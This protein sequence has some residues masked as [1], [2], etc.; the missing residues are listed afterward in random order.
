MAAN[1]PFKLHIV[2]AGRGDAMLIE[3]PDNNGR[4]CLM[5]LD[6]GPASYAPAQGSSTSTPYWKY[7]LSAARRI[8]AGLP[9]RA[10]TT[11]EPSHIVATHAHED[12]VG[13][14]LQLLQAWR[15]DVDN[16]NPLRLDFRGNVYMPA[17]KTHEDHH[18][19]KFWE[20]LISV[21]Y[22]AFHPASSS[23]DTK[24]NI[25]FPPPG[26]LVMFTP[27]QNAGPNDQRIQNIDGLTS[28]DEQTDGSLNLSSILLTTNFTNNLLNPP[29][30]EAL[31]TA[32]SSGWIIHDHVPGHEGHTDEEN[33]RRLGQGHPPLPVV[34][35]HHSV[36][37][38][39]HHGSGI[40][41]C[42]EED[43]P[44]P[45][46][47]IVKEVTLLSI[48]E[49]GN[50]NGLTT[51][52]RRGFFNHRDANQ[53]AD[54]QGLQWL[55]AQLVDI[56]NDTELM[57]GKS[58]QR[59]GNPLHG[60]TLP[61]LLDIF[62][63]RHRNQLATLLGAPA[64]PLSVDAESISYNWVSAQWGKLWDWV[65]GMSAGRKSIG[66]TF[67]W[68]HRLVL[69]YDLS[70]INGD[71]PFQDWFV[72][73][74]SD[75]RNN[76]TN[77]MWWKYWK[78]FINAQS[79][80]NFFM[81]FTAD[82]YV[83]SANYKSHGHPTPNTIVG[84]AWAL[85][86]MKVQ[87]ELFLTSAFSLYIEEI[88]TLT[89]AISGVYQ[90]E[91]VEQTQRALFWHSGRP[92]VPP[93]PLNN[94]PGTVAVPESGA[95]KISHMHNRTYMTVDLEPGIVANRGIEPGYATLN[96]ENVNLA[97]AVD[98][99]NRLESHPGW[100]D[101]NKTTE[102]IWQHFETTI[103]GVDFVMGLGVLQ[104]V[105]M[106]VPN[107]KAKHLVNDYA[108]APLLT[109]QGWDVAGE[110]IDTTVLIDVNN[111]RSVV[112]LIHIP[113]T[114]AWR[115]WVYVQGA[116]EG[117]HFVFN[118]HANDVVWVSDSNLRDLVDPP[119]VPFRVTKTD[120]PPPP[121]APN[122]NLN[123]FM[124]ANTHFMA[125]SRPMMPNA[126]RW[127]NK[128]KRFS[129]NTSNSTALVKRSVIIDETKQP[130]PI[131]DTVQFAEQAKPLDKY[132]EESAS[133]LSGKGKV[134]K[135]RDAL[136]A[137]IQKRNFEKLGFRL[138]YQQAVLEYPVDLEQS[139]AAYTDSPVGTQVSGAQLVLTPPK[140][141]KI[142]IDTEEFEVT[143]AEIWLSWAVDEKL[144]SALFVRTADGQLLRAP[145]T[146]YA[147]KGEPPSLAKVLIG[148]GY[149]DH[150]EEMTLPTL[151]A[152]IFKSPQKAAHLLADRVPAI[153][154]KAG[155]HNLVPDLYA[156]TA[157]ARIGVTKDIGLSRVE[158]LCKSAAASGT[159]K[160]WEP[161][162]KFDDGLEAGMQDVRIIITNANTTA[163]TVTILA[164]AELKMGDFNATASVEAKI[165]TAGA[166]K[167]EKD[168]VEIQFK[169]SGKTPMSDACSLL[170]SKPD[171][172]ALEVPL[173]KGPKLLGNSEPGSGKRDAAG[174]PKN[175]DVPGKSDS[176]ATDLRQKLGSLSS[177]QVGITLR[178][179]VRGANK[180]VVKNVFLAVNLEGW[181]DYL[182]FK[183]P[184]NLHPP[185]IRVM[186]TDPVSEFRAVAVH[187]KTALELKLGKKQ[188][189]ETLDM[190][191]SAVPLV[192]QGEY[193]YR[194][195]VAARQGGLSIYEIVNGIGLQLGEADLLSG[196]PLLEEVAKL[197]YLK[198]ISVAVVDG[199]EGFE[200]GD[201][202]LQI[203]VPQ[204]NLLPSGKL[205]LLNGVMTIT[206]SFKE[207]SAVMTGI[208]SF[209]ATSKQAGVTIRTPTET[210]PG[211]LQI[212]CS[213]PI[214]LKDVSQALELPD[215][216]EMPVIKEIMNI[217]LDSAFF[218]VTNFTK[219][220]K[221]SLKITS[222]RCVF[223]HESLNLGFLTLD[224][225]TVQIG[226]EAAVEK[227]DG[228][229]PKPSRMGLAVSALI[230][231]QSLE[232]RVLYSSSDKKLGARLQPR[233]NLSIASTFD[234]L[235]SEEF[236]QYNILH[237]ILGGLGL[238]QAELHLSLTEGHRIT[239]FILEVSDKNLEAFKK[240]QEPEA[241]LTL[242]T[243]IKLEKLKI[244][245]R[246]PIDESQKG[247]G[248]AG[249]K[250]A[251][252]ETGQGDG[253]QSNGNDTDLKH[254][255]GTAPPAAGDDDD[256]DT[257]TPKPKPMVKPTLKTA[258][259]ITA[260]VSSDKVS[261]VFT[262]NC[263][264]QKG[265]DK[266]ATITIVPKGERVIRSVLGLL[267]FS[268]TDTSE[269][270]K[271]FPQ[272][273]PDCFDIQIERISGTV[274]V[275]NGKLRLRSF[276]FALQSTDS[277]NIFDL[278]GLKLDL[279]N[280]ALR[281]DY[282][283]K[284][285][286][287]GKEPEGL[288][289]VLSAIFQI[290]DSVK[291]GVAYLHKQLGLK[292]AF[293]G[294]T[295]ETKGLQ[296]PELAK[297]IGM[298]PA[299]EDFP[300]VKSKSEGDAEGW[301][302]KQV[303]VVFIPKEYIEISATLTAQITNAI[304]GVTLDLEELKALLRIDSRPVK[305][306][307][308]EEEGRPRTKLL[309]PANKNKLPQDPTV[310]PPKTSREF[311]L[312]GKLRLKGLVAAEAW[313]YI[314][315]GEDTVLTAILKKDT[316]QAATADRALENMT[317]VVATSNEQQPQEQQVQSWDKIVP[318][319]FQ[320][321]Q[322]GETGVS[323]YAN[324]T[325]FKLILAAQI[326]D[327][328]S[329]LLLVK[330]VEEERIP[331]PDTKPEGG[332][333]DVDTGKEPESKKK[334]K[335][336]Y[337]TSMM[338]KD[339]ARLWE[340][341]KQT[342]SD[343][344]PV[345]SV[346]A[347]IQGY[348]S[349]V[350]QIKED[351]QLPAEADEKQ[352]ATSSGVLGVLGRLD[353]ETV[354]DSGAWV[355]ASVDLS[356]DKP[357]A[358]KD[359]VALDVDDTA[360]GSSSV[361][362]YARLVTDN[363][364][365]R[366]AVKDLTLYGGM[367]KF[368]GVGT[369][370]PTP[371]NNDPYFYIGAR[372]DLAL[373]LDSGPQQLQFDVAL[374]LFTNR[375]SFKLHGGAKETAQSLTNP[376]PGMFN[377][378]IKSLGIS[379]TSVKDEKT[380]AITR[381]WK[382]T[383]HAA[384]AVMSPTMSE[385]SA[386]VVFLNG[387]PRVAVLEYT[388]SSK[389]ITMSEVFSGVVEPN[390]PTSNGG[391]VSWPKEEVEDLSFDSAVFSYAKAD[392]G[393]DV[394]ELGD[395]SKYPDGLHLAANLTLFEKPFSISAT[396]PRNRSGVVLRGTYTDKNG[397]DLIFA[398][399]FN[400]SVGIDTTGR[401]AGSTADKIAFTMGSDLVL[402][403]EPGFRIDILYQP[404]SDAKERFFKGQIKYNP[405]Q[406]QDKNSL[407]T[408][409]FGR[410]L[411]VMYK[412]GHWSFGDW[413]LQLFNDAF[414]LLEI[415]EHA[416]HSDG[417]CEALVDLAFKSL[418]GVV[419]TKFHFILGL[420]EKPDPAKPKNELWF[421]VTWA[422]TV[423]VGD[424]ADIFTIEGN[425]KT[426]MTVKVALQGGLSLEKIWDMMKDMLGRK[427]NWDEFGRAL[428]QD[429][430][431]LAL[432]LG[433]LVVEE[434]GEQTVKGIFC[435]G[436]KP[437]NVVKRGKDLFKGPKSDVNR[438]WEAIKKIKKLID[439]I[440]AIGGTIATLIGLGIAIIG[441]IGTFGGMIGGLLLPG[442]LGWFLLNSMA[443]GEEKKE[444]EQ[445]IEELQKYLEDFR[446]RYLET[447]TEISKTGTHRAAH[448]RVLARR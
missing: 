275:E 43:L 382:L 154:L 254:G 264:S 402:F 168:D 186:V 220:D 7:Y 397:I 241:T 100:I 137:M 85:R 244:E 399:L 34:R 393:K 309:P 297:V 151:M 398:T 419:K 430:D 226:Y 268:S 335:N 308:E 267:G 330:T 283:A 185:E 387:K 318:Q 423:S 33:A 438:I 96:F 5:I 272:G 59:Y 169:L 58:F 285:Q 389:G 208:I 147:A 314:K 363:T 216:S 362:V 110:D 197:I 48:L 447:L 207:L 66:T 320:P 260:E 354:I 429:A 179:P 290:N 259:D 175:P 193:E 234:L 236:R 435:R 413:D 441:F 392:E 51:A 106:V 232:V 396:F 403:G 448:G 409:S 269:I 19:N 248:D 164:E 321:L 14:I 446:R 90:N 445:M 405:P 266:I 139:L 134:V 366:I 243:A 162:L 114:E 307:R 412:N 291:I 219:D 56:L 379:G 83:V 273:A 228:D 251:L 372:L 299:S 381:D 167:K 214:G 281:V 97:T 209:P 94:N 199:V 374:D 263:I 364:L 127:S 352:Q 140:N 213:S 183:F 304:G 351:L 384:F 280:M 286:G 246:H 303:A 302:V 349:K 395:G 284:G 328:A 262:I 194:V 215:L 182:P 18:V 116:N 113:N 356:K 102:G 132:F 424:H 35:P 361:T 247:E 368:N 81:T 69:F 166:S 221:R 2:Y 138:K 129:N 434:F 86:E 15:D 176:A 408:T 298:E 60:L 331:K 159:V 406:S 187:I 118:E 6:G 239:Y 74:M 322:V 252:A 53:Q 323:L 117:L 170:P 27:N 292:S 125:M 204:L 225:L 333:T 312:H 365:Y 373:N 111:A 135:T 54:D 201:W 325:T 178:Q 287:T 68:D 222:A 245:Y 153:F 196:V 427:E 25:D 358:M 157:T 353:N 440:A 64:Q 326:G 120:P 79:I 108:Q 152:V 172:S 257:A 444:L 310:Q 12:H 344:F 338:V 52:Y 425:K 205:K 295:L 190:E 150:L 400:P 40:D 345:V 160:E 418:K 357:G 130:L 370:Q 131:A 231:E 235:L 336:V 224:S 23:I 77:T 11:F 340:P 401:S 122:G 177:E 84:L 105:Q 41:C 407:M 20:G 36:Y 240:G 144:K 301:H 341:L 230:A 210:V 359:V 276:G 350:S 173:S 123:N 21:G 332:K 324:F 89:A 29:P 233:K 383:G 93:D 4:G 293:V 346:A 46:T 1:S 211:T 294:G 360:R 99:H 156:S 104:Q 163:E 95:L 319:G 249:G 376:L 13:G 57:Q 37:K 443:D 92:A 88:L 195:A 26:E 433:L 67:V 218:T 311:W 103:K 426:P 431:K 148:M 416:S 115:V 143:D 348:E 253:G 212:D 91:T 165:P 55:Q 146:I 50:N 22:L 30:Q 82:T 278:G 274:V 385:L 180:Y 343:Q 192:L 80:R 390:T 38:I 342:V 107:I 141:A 121:Q 39:Q 203:G 206:E 371:M 282:V 202:S 415:L 31:F 142:T 313:L 237:S 49:I 3:Y 65:R 217:G 442:S 422:Y 388:K 136:G 42:F 289:G 181:K 265:G 47:S 256:E 394:I 28:I 300:P 87:A 386:T 329:V 158:I 24:F 70:N 242:D 227:P 315:T 171:F 184:K 75:V 44:S 191:F 32:D 428:L 124:M 316:A 277:Y 414:N 223:I 327:N 258:L 45:R 198:R 119:Y 305:E 126:A 432:L 420:P 317:D 174:N 410:S 411:T 270:N 391:A 288:R 161:L 149:K 98:V 73:Y 439:T 296:L 61:E 417:A 62:Q 436:A 437:D 369:Y 339:I 112:R 421:T 375:T 188:R 378:T 78:T 229:A 10:N 337:M 255:D 189:E 72:Q 347:H 200:F 133:A 306:I 17:Y 271:E 334:T 155:L 63:E 101:D 404:S 128:S 145:K 250:P 380:G 8:W 355:F 238:D 16:N 279:L 367:L 261:A 76:V 109:F 377:I 71:W 9:G